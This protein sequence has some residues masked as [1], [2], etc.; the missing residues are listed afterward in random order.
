MGRLQD[1]IVETFLKEL[2]ESP[3]IT[4]EMIDTLCVLLAGKKKLKVDDLVKVF[5]P[6]TGEDVE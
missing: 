5:A 2:R 4:P 3:A 1:E 6:P